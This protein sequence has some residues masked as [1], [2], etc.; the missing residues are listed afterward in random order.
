[1]A[2]PLSAAKMLAALKAEGLT[3]HEHAGWKTHNRDAASGKPFGPVI[4][5]LI[6]HTGGHNDKELCYK[7]RSGLPGP[8]CHAWLGK[9]AGLWMI[10]N[11]RTNHAGYADI[12][13]LNALRNEKPLPHDDAATADGNDCLYGL[14][15]ENLGK[16]GDPYPTA[17]YRQAVLW[18]AA[19]CRAHGWSEKSV[20]GHKE[21][22]PGKIDPSFDMDD[23]RA[24]VKK[25]L[26]AGAGKTEPTKPAGKPR[27]DLSRLVKAAKTDPGAK[28][29]HV[30]YMAG[31][32]LTEAALVELGYLSKSHAGDG[33]F[34]T[35]TVAAYA[36]WQRHLGYS[37]ADANGIPGKVSLARL[38]EKTG[39]FTVVA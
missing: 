14:E 8:L 25:Q 30:S 16:S 36:K 22:Q 18:A 1:M 34:G 38:G 3:V 19:I 5:V 6:H 27:V 15:I 24:A 21:C 9:T 35:T 33:S 12:D 4:G 23:F 17:Q 20:A 37:G 39:L 10:G 2:T 11:G 32:N 26:A 31:T 7:G 28:Q 29:G 13:V